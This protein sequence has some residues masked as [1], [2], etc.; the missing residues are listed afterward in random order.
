M[1]HFEAESLKDST[2]NIMP[3]DK[4]GKPIKCI[5]TI[6]AYLLAN[7]EIKLID[8]K[9]TI[10]YP[11]WINNYKLSTA[12]KLKEVM[13]KQIDIYYN[14]GTPKEF[15]EK[16]IDAKNSFIEIV[17]NREKVLNKK[18]LYDKEKLLLFNKV[19]DEIKVNK[20]DSDKNE[21][22]FNVDFPSWLYSGVYDK[23][24]VREITELI[25]NQSIKSLS[26]MTHSEY[27]HHSSNIDSV[28]SSLDN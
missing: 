17:S 2:I 16:M 6:M 10:Y 20:L 5:E 18:R 23:S 19:L 13:N 7:S 12:N 3:V 22:K 26:E 25:T 15:I 9:Y 1:S 8:T 14:E 4:E 11:D 24:L 27:R 28:L 21:T